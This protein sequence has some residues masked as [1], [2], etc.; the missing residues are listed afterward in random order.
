VEEERT[1]ERAKDCIRIVA[2]KGSVRPGNYTS[3]ALALVTDEIEKHAEAT[4]EVID[5]ARMNLPLPGAAEE[6]PDA[7]KLQAAVSQA[8]GV[9][10]STPEYHG[11]YSSVIKLVL[12]NLGFPSALSGKP[13]ALLGVAAGQIGAVK[14]TEHLRSVCSHV[15]ALVLPGPVSVA[16]VQDLFDDDGRCLD[17][18]VERRIRKLAT[19]LIDYIEKH[20]CPRF[21]LEA[22]VRD[23]AA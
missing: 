23:E 5:P 19:S 1:L 2:I 8:T 4:L 3:K 6:T 22:M 17:K 20:I 10:L 7:E 12:E 15:G 16:G 18:R 21:A 14:S 13:V 9:I 11:S